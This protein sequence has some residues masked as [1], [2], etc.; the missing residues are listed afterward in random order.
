VGFAAVLSP[1]VPVVA[2]IVA[3]GVAGFGMGLSYSPL[4]LVVLGEAAQA[5]QGTATA[6]L[7]LSDVVG[8]ALGA[9]VGGAI[10]AGAAHAAAEGWVGLAGAFAVGTAAALVGVGLAR[11]LPGPKRAAA[12]ATA[13]ADGVPS[14]DPPAL[15]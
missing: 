13:P 10:I 9:G 5:E 8:T 4:S 1:D 15:R 3:W 7:Q 14:G 11:R 2:G 12:R 6:G